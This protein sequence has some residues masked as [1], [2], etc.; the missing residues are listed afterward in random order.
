MV[1]VSRSRRFQNVAVRA[2]SRKN[3]LAP[4]SQQHQQGH[5]AIG[6]QAPIVRIQNKFSSIHRDVI[7]LLYYVSFCQ[8]LFS[9]SDNDQMILTKSLDRMFSDMLRLSLWFSEVTSLNKTS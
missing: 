2:V 9:T 7:H 3:F 8:Y 6:D 4:A 1:L 5:Y